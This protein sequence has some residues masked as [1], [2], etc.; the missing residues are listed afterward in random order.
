MQRVAVDSSMLSS[1][2]YDPSLSV[3][4][5]E[6]TEG[7]VYRYFAVPRRIHRELLAA[8][9]LGRYFLAHIRDRYQHERL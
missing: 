3:L 4:E 8:E 7:D 1:V 2:G 5:L 9:S 6:F